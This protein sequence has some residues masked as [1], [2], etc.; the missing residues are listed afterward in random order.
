MLTIYANRVKHSI[1]PRQ[2]EH[3]HNIEGASGGGDGGGGGKGHVR[4]SNDLK[5]MMIVSKIDAKSLST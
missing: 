2:Y 4:R 1:R 5:V 3:E